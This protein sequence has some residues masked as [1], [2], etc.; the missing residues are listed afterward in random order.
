MVESYEFLT[1][2]PP[3]LAIGLV[4]ATRKVLLSLGLGVISAA[5]L[6]AD[7]SPWGTVELV[8]SAFA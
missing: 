8:A 5:F 6:V 1:L 7:G 3:L 2:L 4:V